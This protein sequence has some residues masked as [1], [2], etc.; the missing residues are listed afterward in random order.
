[1]RRRRWPQVATRAAIMTAGMAA[2]MLSLSAAGQRSTQQGTPVFQVD[3]AWPKL[4]NNWVI[5][6]PSSIAVDKH[7]NVWILHRPRTVPAEKKDHAAPPVLVFDNSG[8]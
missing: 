5:G 4:P 3:A 7:D 2:G 6:D 1:M 8:K